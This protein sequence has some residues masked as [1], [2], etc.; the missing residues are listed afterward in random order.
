M[1][2]NQTYIEKAVLSVSNL[3]NEGGYLVPVQAKEFMELLIEESVLL[4]MVTTTPMSA[5]T[6]E[7]SK[8]GFTGRVL[9]AASEGAALP[10]ALRSKP[11]L[12]RVQLTTHEYIAEARIPYGVVEDNIANGT[13]NDVFMRFLA[14]AVARDFEDFAINSDTTSADVDYARQ[15]GLL[16]QQTSLVINAGGIRLQKGILKQALQTMPSRYIKSQKN[17][18]FITSKNAAVDY[19]DSR[20]NRQTPDGDKMIQAAP[21]SVGEYAGYPIVPIPLWPE[22]LGGSQNMTSVTFCDPKNFHVGIQRQVRVETDRDITSREFIIV[23]T[24]RAGW[25][26]AHE[27]ATV[28]VTNVLAAAGY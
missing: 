24:V 20:A 16:K 26:W 9:H 2:S 14:K 17:L 28:K 18:A 8:M 3:I 21:L 19:A 11:E 10:A 25:K 13:F 15:D 6:Y 4:G 7:I 1:A 22:N 23:A 5:P 27:P 12:G